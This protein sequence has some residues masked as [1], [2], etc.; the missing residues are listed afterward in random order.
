MVDDADQGGGV[1]PGTAAQTFSHMTSSGLKLKTASNRG[2]VRAMS[3]S[4][5]K[6]ADF[7]SHRSPERSVLPHSEGSEREAGRLCR[8]L[9]RSSRICLIPAGIS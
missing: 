7:S 5:Q 1:N 4:S 6:T 3:I 8:I 9:I 2:L